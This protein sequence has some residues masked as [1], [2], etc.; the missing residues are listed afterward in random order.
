MFSPGTEAFAS[1]S[2][3]IRNGQICRNDTIT[4]NLSVRKRKQKKRLTKDP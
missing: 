2:H 4:D 1:Y 3:Y